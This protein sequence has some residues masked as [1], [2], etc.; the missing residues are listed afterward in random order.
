MNICLRR[1]ASAMSKQI[2][3]RVVL[4]MKV[5]DLASQMSLKNW[6]PEV[7]LEA[8]ITGGYVGDM[9]SWVMSRAQEGSVWI[10]IMSNQNVAAVALM[11][12]VACVVLAESV[13][14]DEALL[15]Q[16]KKQELPL[17]TSSLSTYEFSC[18]LNAFLADKQIT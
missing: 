10:T 3:Q 9:L 15:A 4:S 12:G 16:A 6:N 2:V 13:E 7:S 11:S 5:K 18:R 17:F 1:F 8:P 14:P